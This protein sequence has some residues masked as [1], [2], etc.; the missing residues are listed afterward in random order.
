MNLVEP[1]RIHPLHMP[2]QIDDEWSNVIPSDII[3]NSSELVLDIMRETELP[4]INLNGTFGQTQNI[5]GI[6]NGQEDS[7]NSSQPRLSQHS[8]KSFLAT[9][10]DEEEYDDM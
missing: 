2:L 3:P 4:E 6:R 7:E 5:A 10:S 9:S 8:K 1:S